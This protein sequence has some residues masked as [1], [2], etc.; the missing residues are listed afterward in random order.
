MGHVSSDLESPG[1]AE[2]ASWKCIL[3]A[4]L[5]PTSPVFMDGRI[6]GARLEPPSDAPESAFV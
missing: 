6:V 5:P 2:V 1:W 3:T 4:R